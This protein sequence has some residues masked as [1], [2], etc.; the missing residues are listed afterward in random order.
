LVQGGAEYNTSPGDCYYANPN[1]NWGD[2]GGAD[3]PRLALDDRTG[4]GPENIQLNEPYVG[5][6]EVYVNV[7]ADNRSDT[8]EPII[9]TVKVW[10]NGVVEYEGS[11]A[12]DAESST[13]DI[14]RKWRVGFVRWNP[15][16]EV[17][18]G[19]DESSP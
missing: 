1:P 8:T 4:Y 14:R 11:K 17:G 13:T 15:P 9:A 10:I 6:Y 16:S 7:F 2:P 12:V 3:D 18:F 5:D 19:P